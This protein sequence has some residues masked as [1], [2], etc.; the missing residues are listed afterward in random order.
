MPGLA[1]AARGRGG[2]TVS[3]ASS[4]SGSARFGLGLRPLLPSA[5]TPALACGGLGRRRRLLLTSAGGS[6]P[7]SSARR[8][9]RAEGGPGRG[10]PRGLL[11]RAGRKRNSTLAAPPRPVAPATLPPE[12]LGLHC[13]ST[14]RGLWSAVRSFIQ[15]TR[16]LRSSPAPR[17]QPRAGETRRPGR[18][19]PDLRARHSHQ[20][21][22]HESARGRGKSAEA[23]K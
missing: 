6:E 2:G 10:Q 21:E 17:A 15:S 19:A 14:G 13:H 12:T 22:S 11:P 5:P 18:H 23:R 16:V 8:R 20:P 7:A 1:A 4:G 9:G 3:A